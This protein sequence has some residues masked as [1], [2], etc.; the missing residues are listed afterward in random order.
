MDRYCIEAVRSFSFDAVLVSEPIYSRIPRPDSLFRA[1]SDCETTGS[2]R[3]HLAPPSS[4]ATR[5]TADQ[6]NRAAVGDT[7]DAVDIAWRVF[8][9]DSPN[10][11]RV[12]ERLRRPV[13][14][15]RK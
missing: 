6:D 3:Q 15:P 2:T 7:P 13:E 12:A 11:L 14:R 8:K 1:L 4:L 5:R 10:H 9:A